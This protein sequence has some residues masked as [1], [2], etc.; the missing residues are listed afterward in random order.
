MVLIKNNLYIKIHD[1][2]PLVG[3]KTKYFSGTVTRP[4]FLIESGQVIHSQKQGFES[5]ID[6]GNEQ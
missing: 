4:S 3:R 2:L 1:G 6:N 5:I